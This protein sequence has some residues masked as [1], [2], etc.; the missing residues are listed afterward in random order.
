MGA[1]KDLTGQRFG[2]L[3]VVKRSDN[4]YISPKGRH[5]VVWECICDCGNRITTNG[6]SLKQGRTKSC[7]CLS[8]EYPHRITHGCYKTKLYQTYRNMIQRCE[9]PHNTDYR[10]YGGRGI[11]VCSEWRN[12]FESFQKWAYENGYD[13]NLSIDRIDVN[14]NYKPSNCRWVDNSIQANN[15]RNNRWITYNGRTLTITKWAEI[16]GLSLSTLRHRLVDLGWSVEKALT[17]K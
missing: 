15:K 16:C 3:V 9:N 2:R 8:M 12:N 10:Y 13:P 4:D 7:G 1:F 5:V 11:G 6:D 17:T 14:G